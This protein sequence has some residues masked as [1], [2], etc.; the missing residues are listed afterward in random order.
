MDRF[1]EIQRIDELILSISKDASNFGIATLNV[2]DMRD[3]LRY[4]KLLKKVANIF[5]EPIE[6][7]DADTDAQSL[8]KVEFKIVDGI[9]CLVFEDGTNIPI[10]T[11]S[12]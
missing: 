4:L 8:K 7:D 9:Q 12:F 11:L 5:D 6:E 2:K 3:V 10:D 1:R